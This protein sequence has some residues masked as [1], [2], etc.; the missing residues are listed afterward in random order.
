MNGLTVP[1]SLQIFFPQSH[2]KFS[3]AHTGIHT[4]ALLSWHSINPFIQ[5]SSD[6]DLQDER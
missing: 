2:D 6:R 5:E 1:I 3:R 4:A